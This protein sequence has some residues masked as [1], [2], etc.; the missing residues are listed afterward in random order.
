MTF[1]FINNLII[2]RGEITASMLLQCNR[3][4]EPIPETKTCMIRNIEF[5]YDKG[6]I[7]D[8]DSE[9]NYKNKINMWL[10]EFAVELNN[11]N[12][13]VEY[14]INKKRTNRIIFKN[15]SP[16]LHKKVVE[17]LNRFGM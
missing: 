3:K 12:V 14:W 7:P 10:S 6:I 5:K 4:D 15:I 17:E 2:S 11:E 16:Q 13:V 8:A 1:S 9:M